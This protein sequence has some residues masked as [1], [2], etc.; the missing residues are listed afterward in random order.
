MT[1]DDFHVSRSRYLNSISKVEQQIVRIMRLA[2]LKVEKLGLGL[3]LRSLKNAKPSCRLSKEHF[4]KLGGI[5]EELASI[6]E[7]RADI[8]HGQLRIVKIDGEAMALFSNP[9]SAKT[10]QSQLVRMISLDGFSQAAARAN[11]LADQLKK[12]GLPTKPKAKAP[13]QSGAPTVI[14]IRVEAQ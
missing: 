13:Q 3:N 9:Q 8:V 2:D 11:K 12:L 6:L 1:E 5:A 10:D 7:E 14:P 4:A